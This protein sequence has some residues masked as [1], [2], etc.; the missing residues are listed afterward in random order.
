MEEKRLRII[1]GCC[2][3][4][5]TEFAVNHVLRL[6]GKAGKAVI[7]DLDI[8]NPYFRSRELTAVF[9]QANVRVIASSIH[10][11]SAEIPS[12][13]PEIFTV[14]Q[15]KNCEAVLDLGGDKA[16]AKV[17]RRFHP[18]LEQEPYEMFYILNCKRPITNDVDRSIRHIR[19]IE[20]A[21]GQS[22]TAIINNAHLC[23]LT[24]EDEILQGQE[25]CEAVGEKTGLPV[26]YTVVHENLAGNLSGK[27][28][29]K[30]YPI[31]IFM[32]KP[33]EFY[34][35]NHGAVSAND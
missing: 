34:E 14:F 24:T 2:G 4:G 5:K 3:S 7:V 17:L 21:S 31:S 20:D 9:D 32:K 33:W 1:T 8:I 6:A 19:E 18:Y 28:R 10:T 15:D 30:I 13:S 29:S 25:L 22:V 35:E 23:E 11:A 16:G 26:V 27:I 12:L